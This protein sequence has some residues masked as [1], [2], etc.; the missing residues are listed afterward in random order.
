MVPYLT[1]DQFKNSKQV[2]MMMITLTFAVFF[3]LKINVIF[4]S[5]L[6]KR[7]CFFQ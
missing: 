5:L 7:S 1:V 6:N 3:Y 4:Y 2:V